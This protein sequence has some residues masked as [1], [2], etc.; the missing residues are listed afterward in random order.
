MGTAKQSPQGRPA[1]FGWE[2]GEPASRQ[3]RIEFLR[4]GIA[5]GDEVVADHNEPD[6]ALHSA[7]ALVSR[8]LESVAPLDHA[9]AA[10]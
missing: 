5:D 4:H 2:S 9:D 1:G 8:A 7:I 10:F 6:P 3:L